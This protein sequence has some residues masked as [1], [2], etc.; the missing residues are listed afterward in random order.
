MNRPQQN[1][2]KPGL[3]PPE[4]AARLR[5]MICAGP[6]AEQVEI[7]CPATNLL[8]GWVPVSTGQDLALAVQRARVAQQSWR[9]TSLKSRAK[10]LMK[11]HDLVLK[12]QAQL[13][14]L[15]QLENGKAR[16]HALEEVLDVAQVTRHY[17]RRVRPYLRSRRRPGALPVLTQTRELHHPKGV[18]GVL[19]PWNYPLTLALTDA[20]PALLAGNAVILKPDLQT[21]FTAAAGL[22][23]MR[24]AGLPPNLFQ[25][26]VGHGPILGAALI[27]VVDYL[28]FTGSTKTGRIVA[29]QAAKRLIGSSLEL[30]GKNGMYIAA[31]ARLPAAISSAVRGCFASTGQ[32]CVST[33]RLILHAEIADEFLAGFI[34][35]VENL[36]IGH[37]LDYQNDLGCLTSAAQLAQ[38]SQQ[39]QDAVQLGAQVLAGGQ[40]RLDLGPYFYEP[41]VL[42]GVTPKA[43]CYAEET[44]GPVVSVYRVG[45]DQEAIDFINQG[46]YGLTASIW[47]RKIR[48]GRKMAAQIIAGTVCIN[49]HYS[50]AWGS[51]S[52]PMGGMRASGIGR[53][54]GREGILKYTESQTVTAQHVVSFSGPDWLSSAQWAKILL[55]IIRLLK[56]TGIR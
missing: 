52:A 55:V 50:A 39:V 45:S 56:W 47:T 21:V 38:V 46:E 29:A 11:F 24:Q 49:D 12:N 15:I 43:R 27:E 9:I 33:E 26:V 25:L 18:I 16:T 14:D 23:L 34:A 1:Q 5:G 31:D 30:G 32:L 7:R 37:S 6:A 54:H 10:I 22:D 17:A 2:P 19:A 8:V 36:K 41:T 40:A 20:I 48:R 44:F 35:R 3:L 13:L 4:Y 42:T 28:C 51:V 53:R